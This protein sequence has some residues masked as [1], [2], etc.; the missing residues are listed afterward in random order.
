MT[1]NSSTTHSHMHILE[2]PPPIAQD[3]NPCVP[4]PCGQNSVCQ[5]QSDRAVC[6]CLPNYLGRPPACRPEC[7][8]NSD[9]SMNMACVNER[10]KDPCAGSCGINAE[11]RVASHSP[12]CHCSEGY[13]GDP[14][15]GCIIVVATQSMCFYYYMQAFILFT[16]IHLLLSAYFCSCFHCTPLKPLSVSLS[17]SL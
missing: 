10:C 3:T 14:F 17:Y 1:W 11:C 9:C 6:S 13:T 2:R 12:Q 15:S 16:R 7:M 4:T 5:V 8:V